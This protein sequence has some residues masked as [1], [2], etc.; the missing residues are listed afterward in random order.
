M[1]AEPCTAEVRVMRRAFTAAIVALV[2]SSPATAQSDGAIRWVVDE[3]FSLAW[4]QVNPHTSLLW[5]TTCSGDPFWRPG[6]SRNSGWD[7]RGLAAPKSGYALVLDT[8][9][10]LYRR[11]AARPFCR[12]AV[13]GEVFVADTVSWK[14][15]HGAITVYPDS[16]ES[17]L[18]ARDRTAR[19]DVFGT[20]TWPSITFKIGSLVNVVPG[21]TMKAD[22]VGTFHFRNVEVPLVAKILAWREPP[23]LRVT[24]RLEMVPTDLVEAYG[25][26]IHG[27]RLG[28]QSGGWR[29]IHFGV[30]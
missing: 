5:A 27:I 20:W 18:A 17:G 19:Q 26:S 23:G 29:M 8:V 7:T 30:D 25:V 1:K 21:D 10:P 28:L 3:P 14:G 4:Y 15:V 12:K 6:E 9:I 11:P 22:G 16:L 13:K 24:G 2:L